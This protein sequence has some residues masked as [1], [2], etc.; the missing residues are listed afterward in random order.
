MFSECIWFQDLSDSPNAESIIDALINWII[1]YI[2][3]VLK[4]KFYITESAN[5]KSLLFFYRF[6]LWEKMKSKAISKLVEDNHFEQIDVKDSSRFIPTDTSKLLTLSSYRF[7][8]KSSG[9]R[10]LNRL[11]PRVS[12]D[13][14]EMKSLLKVILIILKRLHSIS[15]DDTLKPRESLHQKIKKLKSLQTSETLQKLYYIRADIADCYPSINQIKI[16]EI[17]EEL[18]DLISI[19][20][21]ITIKEFDC[22]TKAHKKLFAKHIR[23]VET[24]NF[25]SLSQ[26]AVKNNIKLRDCV[27]IPRFYNKIYNCNQIKHLIKTYIQKAIIKTGRHTYY[28]MKSGIRQGGMLSSELCSIYINSVVKHYFL[29]LGQLPSEVRL[30]QADDFLF[31]TPSLNRANAVI[32]IMLKG[33]DEFNLQINMNK[34]KANFNY[35]AIK[36]NISNDLYFFGHQIN[37]E[38]LNI[39]GDYS[40]YMDHNISYTFNCNPNF[41]LKHIM[42][43]LLSKFYQ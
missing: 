27:L 35:N 33:F 19:N 13:S 5:N 31:I 38:T 12:S 34:L 22:V 24:N 3:I 26:I 9:F 14:Q 2:M 21:C 25:E 10:L 17:I 37:I 32:Q 28:H 8:P 40:V 42:L 41:S 1:D 20:N 6:D 11:K 43:T 29:D 18:I 7:V 39:F 4:A 15:S 30:I 23:Y 16:Y 36:S